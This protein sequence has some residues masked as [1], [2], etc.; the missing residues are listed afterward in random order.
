M[1]IPCVLF[2]PQSPLCWFCW[3]ER[4]V[5]LWVLGGYRAATLQCCDWGCIWDIDSREKR[6]KGKKGKPEMRTLL[7]FSVLQRPIFLILSPE[8]W[9]PLYFF[10]CACSALGSYLVPCWEIKGKITQ[11]AYPCYWSFFQLLLTSLI[12]LLLTVWSPE[13]IAFS[14]MSRGFN[15]YEWGER[16]A[17]LHFARDSYTY[18]FF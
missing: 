4:R 13:I 15:W 2:V 10:G 8:I 3:P 11:D 18:F 9:L 6:E 16:E 17:V 12:H 14:I 1:G 7:T 5:C